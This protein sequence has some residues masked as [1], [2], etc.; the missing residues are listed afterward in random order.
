MKNYKRLKIALSIIIF[1]ILLFISNNVF[2]M[3]ADETDELIKKIAPDGV[4]ATFKV[5]RPKDAS[6]GDL[7]INGYVSRI[8]SGEG[9]YVYAG[10]CTEPFD[11]CSIQINSEDYNGFDK[12]W[13]KNYEINVTYDE[14]KSN[15][16]IDNYFSKMRDFDEGDV[17]TAYMVEDLSLINYYLTSNKSELWNPGAAGRALRYS[18]INEITKGSDISYY[19]DIR[20]GIQDETLMFESAFGEMSIFYNDYSY[21]TKQQGVYLKRVIYIPQDTEDTKEAFVAAAQKRINDY[22]GNDSVTVT[23]GGLISSLVHAEDPDYP[24]ISD[25]NYYNIKVG[26]RTYKFYIVKASND[27]L[28]EPTYIGTNIDSKIEVT[29]DNSSIPLDTSVT[30]IN[31]KDTSVKDKIGTENYKS[32]D[33][34]LYS[35]AQNAKIEELDN[36]KFIVRIPIPE[37]LKGKD[38]IVY[39][40]TTAG[41]LEKHTVT[42]EN[43]YAVFETDHFSTYTL[44]EKVASTSNNNNKSGMAKDDTPPTGTIDILGYVLGITLVSGLGIVMIKRKM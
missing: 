17:N 6:E 35:D 40:L 21:Y 15:S 24:I 2:A 20:A 38:L 8:L 34:K 31:V 9:Y 11:K 44:A 33:I 30:V 16:A 7:V 22:L 41:E 23:Y 12:G 19:I 29:S 10:A 13:T 5:R 39:Y 25:G 26:S 42:L 1:A 37:E 3:T 28:V 32:Y 27:K 36:G 14:P 4:N 43:G 18:T